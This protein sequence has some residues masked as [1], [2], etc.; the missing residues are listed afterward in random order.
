MLVVQVPSGLFREEVSSS[1]CAGVHEKYS[2][3]IN[4]I[5]STT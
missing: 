3:W 4:V 2:K 1:G 5:T